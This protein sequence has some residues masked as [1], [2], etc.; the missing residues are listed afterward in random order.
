L[1]GRVTTS[2]PYLL[3]SLF[4]MTSTAFSDHIAG[5]PPDQGNPVSLGDGLQHVVHIPS[6]ELKSLLSQKKNSGGETT[7][8]YYLPGLICMHKFF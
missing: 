2:I 6:T 1:T 4:P 5:Y 3:L 7:H 8:V